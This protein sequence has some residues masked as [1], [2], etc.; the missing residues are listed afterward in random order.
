MPEKTDAHRPLPILGWREWLAL[1][2]LKIDWVKAKVDTGARTSALHAYFVEP[3]EKDGVAHARFGIHP[4]QKNCDLAVICEAEVIDSRQ[5]KDSGGHEEQRLV[6]VTPVRIG[7]AAWPIEITL[8]NR[9][10]MGFRMLIGRTAIENRYV[11]DAGR[12]YLSREE[13]ATPLSK[14][15]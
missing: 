7:N 13:P 3:F 8:T 14:T 6:I 15:K 4:L 5:I 10:T 1:P 9:E 12:S 2:E 11:V